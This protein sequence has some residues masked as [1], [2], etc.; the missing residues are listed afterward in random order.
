MAHARSDGAG[1][2]GWRAHASM[3]RLSVWSGCQCGMPAAAMKASPIVSTCATRSATRRERDPIQ[4]AKRHQAVERSDI[5]RAGAIHR[6]AEAAAE[7]IRSDQVG[8][9][10]ARLEQAEAGG[11]RIISDQIGSDR[12]RWDMVR[13]ALNRPKLVQKPS[14]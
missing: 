12:I 3:A 13:R 11:E 7:R 2:Q 1:T 5:G 8:Y 9:G 14:I 10:A 4:D 6:P